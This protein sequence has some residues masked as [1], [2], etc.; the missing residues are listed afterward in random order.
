M[1]VRTLLVTGFV[2]SICAGLLAAGCSE[3]TV[4]PVKDTDDLLAPPAEGQGVQFK[5][6]STLEAGVETE[7]CKFFVAPPGGL[8][9]NNEVVR[10][11]AGSHHVLLF[12]TGYD[13]I[14]TV[15]KNGNAFDPEDVLEC[16]DGASADWDVNGVVGGS[17]TADG[18]PIVDLPKGVAL[19]IPE[20]TVMVMNTHYLNAS[21]EAIETDA[22][23]NLLT[24][25]PEEVEQ[26]AG[27]L[28]W[29]DF[30]IHAKAQGKG[31][32]R[33]SCPIHQ[34]ITLVNAQSH[35][36]KRGVSYEANLLDADGAKVET[37]YT[38]DDWEQVPVTQYENKVIKAG[39]RIDYQC[40]YEN[41]EAHDIYQGL[42]TRDEMCMFIGLYYPRESGTEYCAPEGGD[43]GN[44]SEAATFMGT[45]TKSCSE[46]AGCIYSVDLGAEHGFDDYQA[47]VIDTC[48]SAGRQMSDV[49]RC[50]F[51][52]A[53]GKCDAACNNGGD[54]NQCLLTECDP[55]IQACLDA[56][57][58]G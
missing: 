46:F 41:T 8:Y 18:P 28:F 35:M 23:I 19:K 9:V 45:G 6:V 39:S 16:P 3:E 57:C 48:P 38:S 58:D 1:F 44:L 34:D 5:M 11:T 26:E 15:D 50:Q 10:F 29:Y 30:F 17:Q 43:F 20:G 47:C 32:A 7:R 31:G 37:L 52:N 36:H 14:P 40:N 21:G 4:A 13:A 42:T 54:C 22:R 55:Q 27:I 25:P 12:T 24:V 49:I 2:G 51:S 53:G 33:M 56:T